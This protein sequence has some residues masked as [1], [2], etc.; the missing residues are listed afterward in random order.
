MLIFIGTPMEPAN[1][2]WYDLSEEEEIEAAKAKCEELDDY[3]ISDYDID[4]WSE[5]V[6]SCHLQSESNLEYYLDLQETME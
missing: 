5:F 4:T 6:D 3:L 2:R 1:G